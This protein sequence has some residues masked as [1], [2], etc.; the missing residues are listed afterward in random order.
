MERY[1]PEQLKIKKISNT[2]NISGKT[3]FMKTGN[4]SFKA[5][6]TILLILIVPV[7]IGFLMMIFMAG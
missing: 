4:L 5:N 7:I 3:N 6:N 2:V 1:R